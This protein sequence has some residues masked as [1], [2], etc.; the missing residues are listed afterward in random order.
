MI[1]WV[2]LRI[3]LASAALIGT[4]F[5]A[6]FVE[7]VCADEEIVPSTSGE[8][9]SEQDRRVD[10]I[11][12]LLRMEF[13]VKEFTFA[14]VRYQTPRGRRSTWMVD[15]PDADLG[16]SLRLSQW[17]NLKVAT[18]PVVVSLTDDL[19][20]FPILYMSGGQI[21]LAEEEATGLRQYFDQGGFLLVDDFHGEQEWANLLAEM[22]K[23]Y[24]AFAPVDLPLS[25][26]VFQYPFRLTEKPQVCSIAM[27]MRHRN[28]GATWDREDGKTVHY[29]A[30]RDPKS[31][32]LLAIFCHN[33]D[34]G[35][36]WEREDAS[37]WYRK[38]FSEKRAYPMGI[39][40]F[41]HVLRGQ[42]DR[43]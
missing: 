29:W 9:R 37:A 12:A 43:K 31:K 30:L 3:R 17:T 1:T 33:T 38:E 25:D 39:N 6:C 5:G 24:P 36:G 42:T 32:K 34:L 14:R 2:G 13:P 19:K 20:K 15:F 11:N 16:F 26:P 23:V 22:R 18:N 40:I 10:S 35:D 7:P 27:A 8:D 41:T 28:T 4:L 21:V